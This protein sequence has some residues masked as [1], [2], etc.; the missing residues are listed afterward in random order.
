MLVVIE[1]PS[2]VGKTTLL[3]AMPPEQVIGEEALLIP[4]GTD[5]LAAER[6]GVELN[7]RRW[8]RL[9]AAE[10]RYGRAY[11]DSDPLKLYYG[12]ALA[13]EG[14]LQREVFE[15]GWRLAR[16]ALSEERLG[17]ADRV[18]F[19]S[20]SPR[21]L[22]ERRAGDSSRRRGKFSSHVRLIDAFALYYAALER[23]RPGMLRWLDAE[24]DLRGDAMA[25]IAGLGPSEHGR[26]DVSLLDGLKRELDRVLAAGRAPSRAWFWTERWQ[27]MEREADGEYAAGRHRVYD[28]VESFLADLEESARE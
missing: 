22:A 21:T 1:G 19:L 10:R 13:A 11:A 2:A 5:L 12:F 27:R 23:A 26:Y 15:E 14:E 24:G 9:V 20:A 8:E 7:A 6:Y 16:R 4:P 18:V 3:T 17:F 28:D 25:L